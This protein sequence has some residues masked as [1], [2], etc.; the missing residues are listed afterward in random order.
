MTLHS[1]WQNFC[2]AQQAGA[3][4]W[5]GATRLDAEWWGVVSC[6]VGVTSVPELCITELTPD[7]AFIILASDGVWEF[8]GNQE[9][10]DIIGSS[11]SVEEGCRSVSSPEADC[12]TQ[13][14]CLPDSRSTA[15]CSPLKSICFSGRH[16]LIDCPSE[17]A[18]RWCICFAVGNLSSLCL[19]E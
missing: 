13:L 15:A 16:H 2:P 1:S 6:R 5:S 17:S 3:H 18:C 14:Q 11:K 12:S 7:D 19:Q 9:A 8:I 10:V 4:Q